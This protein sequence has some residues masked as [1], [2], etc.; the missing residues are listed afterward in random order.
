MTLI[1]A[2][3]SL[4]ECANNFIHVKKT[5]CRTNP[6]LLNYRTYSASMLFQKNMSNARLF[7]APRNAQIV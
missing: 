6:D 1:V 3:D 2:S 4:A 5:C 7:P